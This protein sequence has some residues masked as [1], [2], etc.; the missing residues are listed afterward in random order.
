MIKKQ[1]FTLIELL[2]VVTIIA[3]LLS[4]LLPSLANAKEAARRAVCLSNQKQLHTMSM[5][6]AKENNQWIPRGA[7]NDGA[8]SEEKNAFSIYRMREYIGI[9]QKV[10]GGVINNT[11]GYKA[12]FADYEVLQCPSF[13][14]DAVLTYVVNSMDF[15]K[16]A[17]GTVTEMHHAA[18]KGYDLITSPQFADETCLFTELNSSVLGFSDFNNYNIWKYT[19]MPFSEFGAPQFSGRMLNSASNEHYGKG[20]AV[21]F[22]GHASIYSNKSAGLFTGSFINGN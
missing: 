10:A 7:M 17:K 4:L 13:D 6:F 22:D 9:D 20:V 12:L 3:I 14:K 1:S 5:L 16:A 2:I 8:N 18:S 19:D 15:K 21:F 11:S